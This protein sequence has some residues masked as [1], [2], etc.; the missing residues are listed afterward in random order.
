MKAA[1]IGGAGLLGSAVIAELTA[2]DLFREITLIDAQAELG[3]AEVQDLRAAHSESDTRLAFAAQLECAADSD[4]IIITRSFT[5]QCN[6]ARL[7][8]AQRNLAPFCW[9]LSELNRVGI[10]S[11]AVVVITTEPTELMTALA[12]AYLN[13]PPNQILGMGTVVDARRLRAGLA[14]HF[15]LP[16]REIEINAVGVRGKYLIPLWSSAMIGSQPMS[17]IRPWEGTWQY[18]VETATR[19]ADDMQLRGKGGSWRTA[20]ASVVDVAKAVAQNQRTQLPVCVTRNLRIPVYGLRRTS[21]AL[22]TM[23]GREGAIEVI[24]QKLWPKELAA[25]RQASHQSQRDLNSLAKQR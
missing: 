18:E 19:Q 8:L 23:V 2:H 13:L 6:E 5:P 1:V 10:K 16:A 24:E 3:E 15:S 22:P 21:I 9:L 11:D 12:A 4:V 20:A 25:L 14:Q 17:K 7:A